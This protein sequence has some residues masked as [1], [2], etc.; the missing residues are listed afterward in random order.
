MGT[1]GPD[2]RE[3]ETGDQN[4]QR[5][6]LTCGQPEED[7]VDRGPPERQLALNTCIH[8]WGEGGGPLT[9]KRALHT[10]RQDMKEGG[11]TPHGSARLLS[12]ARG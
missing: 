2:E 5:A 9:Q 11:R 8:Q 7:N 3:T 4:R 1:G 10:H 6:L 12:E